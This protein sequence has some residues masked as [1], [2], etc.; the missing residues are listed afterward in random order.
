MNVGLR[1]GTI[2]C[3]TLFSSVFVATATYAQ[4]SQFGSGQS[5]RLQPSQDSVNQLF[6]LANQARAAHGLGALKWDPALAAAAMRHCERMARAGSISHQYSGEAD[7]DGRAGQAAAHFSLIEENVAT[8]PYADGIHQGWMNSPGHRANLLSPA[9]DRVG[10]AVVARGHQLYAVAD[11]SRAVPVL[12]QTQVEGNIAAALRARG[13]S[14]QNDPSVAR[15]YCASP[16]RFEGTASPSFLM[17]W[18]NADANELPRDL[19]ERI[20]SGQYR[21]AVVGS[22]APQGIGSFTAYRIAVLLYGAE[23]AEL[24]TR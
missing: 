11:Y 3:L 24:R 6:S 15:A 1:Q 4:S 12:T 7:V 21:E 17:R 8:G 9:I 23:T 10:L 19:Q 5:G 14:I 16:A 20:S 22:C 13:L 18:Q 2:L